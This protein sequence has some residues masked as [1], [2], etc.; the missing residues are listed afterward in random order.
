[1]VTAKGKITLHQ[2]RPEPLIGKPS[3]VVAF[4]VTTVVK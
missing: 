3:E 1:L 2:Q 4:S